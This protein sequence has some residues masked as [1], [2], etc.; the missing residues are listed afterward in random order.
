MNRYFADLHIHLGR[1]EDNLPIKITAAR[2]MTFQS[3]VTEASKRKGIS[4]IGIIDSHSPPVQKEIEIGLA[5]GIYQEHPDGGIIF[6]DTVCILGVEVECKEPT[7][8]P[9]HLLAYFPTLANIK[10]F[11]KYLQK[12]MKNVQLSTQRL[13][14]PVT[15]FVEQVKMLDGF[16]IPAHIFTPFK[17]VYGSASDSLKDLFQLNSLV[18]VELGLS[19]DTTMA[20]QISE[21]QALTF[22]TNSDAHSL[23]KIGREYN[24]LWIEEPSFLELE[25]ALKRQQGRQVITNYGLNPQLGK[26]YR[27]RCLLCNQLN[28]TKKPTC[29]DCNS[30]KRVVG[31]KDRILSIADQTSHSPNHRPPYIHQVPLEFIPSVGKRTI[32]Q[33]LTHFG[34]EMNVIHRVPMEDIA[35]VTSVAIAEKINKARL[36]HLTFTQGGGGRYGKVT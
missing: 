4:L 31:V 7:T 33:L 15:A 12:H 32:D 9:F 27:T 14:Q 16:V 1:T 35:K 8:G 29:P 17:S 2:N 10:Q 26:Y 28:L 22:V 6:Q 13:Y 30:P 36:G 3:V 18:A 11:T 24:E 19:A 20:D 34:T 5:T 25:R 21:L 23:P